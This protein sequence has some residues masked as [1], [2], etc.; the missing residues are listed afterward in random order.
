MNK[1]H[2]ILLAL[3]ALMLSGCNKE[4]SAADAKAKAKEIEEHEVKAEDY[5]A[6]TVSASLV[7]E[8]VGKVDGQEGNQKAEMKTLVEFSV[9]QNYIHTLTYEKEQDV[10]NDKTDLYDVESWTYLKD[11]ALIVAVRQ[12]DGKEEEKTY[13]SISGVADVAKAAFQKALDPVVKSALE[14]ASSK[15]MLKEVEEMADEKVPEGSKYDVKYYTSGDGNLTVEGTATF[16]DYAYDGMKGSGT[17]K[18]KYAWDQYLLAE[19]AA[20]MELKVV[21][22]E[23]DTDATMKMDMQEAIKFE[24]GVAYPDLS[25]FKQATL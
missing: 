6:L 16:T 5:K 14:T 20:S 15:E 18:V 25:Q 8:A 9:E 11:D 2:L 21:D 7:T 19:V 24:C 13:T 23:S 3:P 12:N 10:K 22:A 4:I 17:G 1:K